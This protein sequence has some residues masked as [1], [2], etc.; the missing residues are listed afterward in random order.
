MNH[1]KTYQSM[2]QNNLLYFQHVNLTQEIQNYITLSSGTII[3]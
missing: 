3:S 1:Q 2:Y